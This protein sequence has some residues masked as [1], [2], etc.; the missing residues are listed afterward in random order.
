VDCGPWAQTGTGDL[1]FSDRRIRGK[2]NSKNLENNTG[3]NSFSN[4]CGGFS[5]NGQLGEGR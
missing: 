4:K 2:K 5:E 1:P 3:Q